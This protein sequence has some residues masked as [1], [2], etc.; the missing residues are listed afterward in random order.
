M[1][2]VR[3]DI[4]AAIPKLKVHGR[5]IF[6]DYIIWNHLRGKPYGVVR[7]VNELLCRNEEWKIV[8]FCL[9]VEMF[10]DVAVSRV[11]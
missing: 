7:A 9:N 4:A 5:L 10:C 11:N 8:A 6:N 1:R 2:K 3:A